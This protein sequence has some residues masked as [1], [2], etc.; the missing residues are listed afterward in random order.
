MHA[1]S[2]G[3]P[4]LPDPYVRT[5]ATSAA[6]IT[7]PF[8]SPGRSLLTVAVRIG[9][10]FA[11]ALAM[12]ALL[13]FSVKSRL[14]AGAEERQWV[15][16]SL[17]VLRVNEQVFRTLLQAESAGRGFQLTQAPI[18]RQLHESAVID[19]ERS[20][21]ELRALTL[22]NPRQRQFV[23]T[24][25]PVARQRVDATRMLFDP[26][27][28]QVQETIYS[29]TALMDRARQL[30]RAINQE[31]SR[32]LKERR[33]RART[34]EAITRQ[35]V[36]YGAWFAVFATAFIG[37]LVTRSILRPVQ[38]LALGAERVGKGEYFQTVSINRQDELGRLATAFNEMAAR[39]AA[40]EQALSEQHWMNASMG[41]LS[42]LMEGA[43]DPAVL[44]S[45]ILAECADLLGVQQSLVYVPDAAAPDYLQLQASYASEQPPQRIVVGQ[46]LI[47]QCYRAANGV[48]LDKVPDDYLRVSSGLGYAKPAQV[49][50]MPAIF[51]GQVKAILELASLTA[52]SSTK[53]TLLRRFC[54]SFATVLHA[55]DASKRTEQL[56]TEATE[57]STR[58]RE[59]Q[60]ELQQSNGELEHVNEE[61]Q[62]SNVEME[63]KATVLEEQREVIERA[64]KEI[65]RS[66]AA[67]EDKVQ[68][69][70]LSSKYK[71]EFLANMSHELRTPLNSLLILSKILAENAEG[72]LT[73]KQV[74]RANTI[75]GAGYDLLELINDILDLA[76]IESGT[77]TADAELMRVNDLVG[78]LRQAFT[79]VAES[80]NLYFKIDVGSDVPESITT[81]ARRLQQILRN[82]LS[83]AFKF[84]SKG[85][86]TLKIER[87]TSDWGGK[88]ATL[89]A[90][91]TVIAFRV[92]DT[93][94]GVPDDR[95]EIVFEAFQQADA[96][97]ARRYGGTGLGL[98][99]SRELTRVLQG[100]LTL[101]STPGVGSTFSLYL[102]RVLVEVPTQPAAALISTPV[103][104]PRTI[105]LPDEESVDSELLDDP[106]EA[107]DD[108]RS[109]L[110]TGDRVLLV[111]ED[112]RSFAAVVADFA[113][114]K[115]FKVIIE[116]SAQ[117]A[118]R[119]TKR[120]RPCAI[121]LDLLLKDSNGWAVLDRLKHDPELRH[122]PVHVISVD[123][124]RERALMQGAMSFLHKP[125]TREMLDTVL[126]ETLS[127]IDDPVRRLLIVEDDARQRQ[128]IVELF[129]DSEVEV[130]AKATAAAALHELS[131]RRFHCMIADLGLPDMSGADLIAT[132]H[133]RYGK[134]SPPVVIYTGKPLTRAEETELRAISEAIVVKDAH[135]PERLLDETSLFLHYAPSRMSEARQ[136][137]LERARKDDPVL[138]GRSVL[139]VD[140]D[141]RNIFAITAGLESHHMRVR[142]AESG[143]AA[144]EILQTPE[145]FDVVLMDVMM[146]EMDGFEAIRRIRL[147]E[148]HANLPIIVLTAKAM[149][150][151]REQCLQAGASDYLSKPVDLDQLRSMLRVWLYKNR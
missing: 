57:M 10:G 103:P 46:G 66:R 131:E 133:H 27:N 61:L 22:D 19:L 144:L 5:E 141:V 110:A 15:Q 91:D 77:V 44:S 140:D 143:A 24:L 49:V 43:R 126:G 124:Q 80:S 81:D 30:T 120:F 119:A 47:G 151:A 85:G 2:L 106:A 134:T 37:W 100:A 75:H 116:R 79:H 99:I 53:L 62:Q 23:T 14:A 135:S 68:Q 95:R 149:A 113:R 137:L 4:G 127:L 38:A 71:S 16:H 72:T 64:N 118:L 101:E 34:A 146:P 111:I 20:M 86:V 67:L 69:L 28:R 89:A 108:D 41:R 54:D 7:T 55:L 13:S 39:I 139:V 74:E 98:S 76:K 150:R 59:Q 33:E 45:K 9:A 132:M 125:V 82:L 18:F 63:E 12:L 11:A 117:D 42:R 48:V 83:N 114:E 130:V 35:L 115:G 26:S 145:H 6:S 142:Y 73:P 148:R 102:P 52:F 8:A 109:K 121:T 31:D 29:G 147:I 122:V 40:R 129:G 104:V 92:I 96:G 87:V 128:A 50:I 25:V 36:A 105:G 107:P 3:Q 32:L 1:S 136:R 138:R 56:L 97:T 94:I 78:H 17:E 70:A 93:G 123:D 88:V 60:A 51:E 84:T 112:D 65:E 58:L 21:T 90:A